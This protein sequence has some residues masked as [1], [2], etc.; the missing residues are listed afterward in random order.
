MEMCGV[1]WEEVASTLKNSTGSLMNRAGGNEIFLL[2]K[3]FNPKLKKELTKCGG[4]L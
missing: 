4:F 3:S 2:K 1:V